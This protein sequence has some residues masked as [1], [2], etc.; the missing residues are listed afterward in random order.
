MKNE[1]YDA[2]ELWKQE[3][4]KEGYE[5]HC[6]SVE[7]IK[8]LKKFGRVWNKIFKSTAV[9]PPARLFELGCGGGK[10]LAQLALNGF[11]VHGIDVSEAVATNAQN[12]LEEIRAF[13]PIKAHVEVANI[14][15]YQ[16]SKTYDMCFHFGVVEHFLKSAERY[17]VWEKLVALTRPGGWVVSVVPCGRHF[18]R[19]MMRNQRLGGYNIPE[20]DYA[21]SLHRSEFNRFNLNPIITIPH[22]YFAFLSAHSLPIVSKVLYPIFFILGNLSFPYLP[23]SD[24]IKETCAATLIVIGQRPN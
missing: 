23:L 7:E 24:T 1:H 16:S 19:A 2:S 11:E 17:Q 5:H 21:C 3:L 20:I 13:Q 14:F 22:N 10:H 15:E 12:Y 4:K 8:L 6:H 9:A 18:M